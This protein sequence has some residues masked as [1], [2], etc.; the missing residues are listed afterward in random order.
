MLPSNG[1]NKKDFQFRSDDMYP[2][3]NIYNLA[4]NRYSEQASRVS[5]GLRTHFPLNLLQPGSVCTLPAGKR[6]GLVAFNM[7]E[8][9]TLML[10]TFD[11]VF[12]SHWVKGH[13]VYLFL[14]FFFSFFFLLFFT[15]L[16][17]PVL[18]F[19]LFSFGQFTTEQQQQ[20]NTSNKASRS[21]RCI[22]SWCRLVAQSVEAELILHW[23][24][25]VFLILP[26]EP[27]ASVW[28]WL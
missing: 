17:C 15:N 23:V 27:A 6:D 2:E 26:Q 1:T 24:I 12:K 4:L 5:R 14:F 7:M 16:V 9:S 20:S 3:M 18:L 22:F 21:K 8:Q 11:L 25:W 19:F 10:P 28:A 13:N